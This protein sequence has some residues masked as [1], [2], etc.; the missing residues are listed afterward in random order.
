MRQGCASP[1]GVLVKASWKNFWPYNTD[2]SSAGA[3]G[4]LVTLG[5]HGIPALSSGYYGVFY[6]LEH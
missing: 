1:S 3:E 2:V 5:Q 4:A 6:F